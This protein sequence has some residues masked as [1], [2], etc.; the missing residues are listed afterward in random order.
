[1]AKAADSPWLSPLLL[2][3]PSRRLLLRMS[4]VGAKLILPSAAILMLV[5]LAKW[6]SDGDIGGSERLRE[7]A[8]N[9]FGASRFEE[10]TLSATYVCSLACFVRLGENVHESVIMMLRFT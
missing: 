7:A 4:V 5:V 8:E 2:P 1:M 9:F 3:R 6:A 10:V